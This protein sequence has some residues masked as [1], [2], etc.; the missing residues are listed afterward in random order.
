MGLFCPRL[1]AILVF[2]RSLADSCSAIGIGLG[3]VATTGAVLRKLQQFA[4]MTE[5]EP[6][7]RFIVDENFRIA[8]RRNFFD[9]SLD[10]TGELGN[11]FAERTCLGIMIQRSS[12][13]HGSI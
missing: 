5:C 13:P 7:W 10:A 11:G 12:F 8:E 6:N 9:E 1:A 4:S 3:F 2:Y